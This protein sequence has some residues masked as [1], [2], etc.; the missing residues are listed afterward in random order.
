MDAVEGMGLRDVVLVGHSYSGTPVGQ[1]AERIGPRPARVVFVDANVPANGESFVSA[2]PDGRSVV[3]ASMARNGGFWAPPA[4]DDCEGQGLT[5]EQIA[6][7]VAGATPHP[8]ATLTEPAVLTRPLGELPATY[9]K[10][11]LDGAEPNGDVVELLKSERWRLVEMETGHWPMFSQPHELARILLAEAPAPEPCSPRA[12]APRRGRSACRPGCCR[13]GPGSG[14]WRDRARWYVPPSP[15][16]TFR[17]P[18]RH[19]RR[20]SLHPASGTSRSAAMAGRGRQLAGTFRMTRAQS[21]ATLP[22]GNRSG[23]SKKDEEAPMTRP[24]STFQA[25]V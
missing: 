25:A 4:P 23:S 14:A 21:R 7:I 11:L 17:R 9:L 22:G 16:R 13:R 2:W 6:R 18:A 19:G 10:C 8:G 12:G 5:D 20:P 24:A 15:A 3:E 1:A